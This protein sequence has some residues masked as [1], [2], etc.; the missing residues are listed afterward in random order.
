MQSG[1]RI[2]LVVPNALFRRELSGLLSSAGHS[3]QTCGSLA[4]ASRGVASRPQPDL[5]IA[6]PS[7]ADAKAEDA[8]AE[9]CL[10]S[11]VPVICILVDQPRGM[12]TVELGRRVKELGARDVVHRTARPGASIVLGPILLRKITN[13]RMPSATAIHRPM[14]PRGEMRHRE[15]QRKRPSERPPPTACKTGAPASSAPTSPTDRFPIFLI[16]CS[17]GG[18][19]AL[20]QVISMLPAEFPGALVVAQHMRAGATTAFVKRLARQVRMDVVEVVDTTLLAPGVCHVA[21]GGAD[22]VF[23][24]KRN[25]FAVSSVPADPRLPF[26]PSVDRMVRSAAQH[27]PLRRLRS[28]LL[29]GIG[30]DGADSMAELAAQGVPAIAESAETCIVH[31]MPARLAERAPSAVVLP[32][33]RIASSMGELLSIARPPAPTD[34]AREAR[35]RLAALAQKTGKD[36]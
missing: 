12:T 28:L 11:P 10:A 27:V 36:G 35:S 15:A 34:K 7:L 9:L 31:G 2:L 6:E 26:H 32:L 8:L 24:R 33:D 18:P 20:E 30:Q 29:T 16:G 5:V 21:A 13:H 3:V 23:S 14:Q 1:A 22:I 25:S 17:T 4:E 19:N